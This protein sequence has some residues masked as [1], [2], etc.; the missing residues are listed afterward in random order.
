MTIINQNT[1]LEN[2]NRLRALVDHDTF[3]SMNSYEQSPRSELFS[4]DQLERHAK[5][6]AERHEIDPISGK[7]LL[8]PRLAENEKILLQVYEQLREAMASNLRIASA[9]EL[10]FD[11]F[12]KIEEQVRMARQHLPKGYSKELPHLQRGPLAGYPRV[13]ELA[14]ELILHTDGR[15]DSESLKRFVR[16]VSNGQCAETG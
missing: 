1:V 5:A 9:S 14:R 15:V 10:L 6:L 16:C 12:Y 7:D 3:L 2:L 11:N 8:L 13:Y 4:N